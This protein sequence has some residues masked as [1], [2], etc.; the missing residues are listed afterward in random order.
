MRSVV[1]APC[2]TAYAP[3]FAEQK[4]LAA[5]IQAQAFEDVPYL[6]GLA[7]FPTAFRADLIDIPH[8][9]PAFWG[10]RRI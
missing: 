7:Y 8:G 2:F 10:V 1:T 6:L 3:D 4:K 5:E 9:Y